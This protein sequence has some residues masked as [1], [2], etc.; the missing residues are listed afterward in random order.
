MPN[1][2]NWSSER[3]WNRAETIINSNSHK[4]IRPHPLRQNPKQWPR[5]SVAARIAGR[6]IYF[7]VV[8][9]NYSLALI[10]Y[11]GFHIIQLIPE[12]WN[13]HWE[14]QRYLSLNVPK[15][16]V[17]R[18]PDSIASECIFFNS[19]TLAVSRTQIIFS[20]SWLILQIQFYFRAEQAR[21]FQVHT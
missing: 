4:N 9:P 13:H 3:G 21:E 16:E 20:R 10:F 15:S 6:L 14:N 12:A 2:F 8:H 19:S 1:Y 17:F 5:S 18:L 7:D 11:T